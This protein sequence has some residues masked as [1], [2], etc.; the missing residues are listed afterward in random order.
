M[1]SMSAAFLRLGP[2]ALSLID[3]FQLLNSDPLI[4]LPARITP[5]KNI[6][7]ALRVLASLRESHPAA[8]LL[9]TGPTGPHNPANSEVSESLIELRKVLHVEQEAVFLATAYPKAVSDELLLD[10]YRLADVLLFPSREEGFGIPLLEAG[11][12]RIPVFCADIEPLREVGGPDV[13]YF[14]PDGDPR[15]VA[16]RLADGTGGR[17]ASRTPQTGAA[18]V[19]LAQHL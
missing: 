11:L 7:M 15:S 18:A 5:R 10:L 12:E 2:E 8:R 9:V 1:D 14:P 3:E 6:E 13:E 19:C 17:Q 16:Q 4:L